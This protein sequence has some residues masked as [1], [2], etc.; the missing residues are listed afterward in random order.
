[1]SHA[2]DDAKEA[3]SMK[4]SFYHKTKTKREKATTTTEKNA[5][6]IPASDLFSLTFE[7]VAFH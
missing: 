4:T 1:M 5:L 3:I 7:M 6:S 2:S